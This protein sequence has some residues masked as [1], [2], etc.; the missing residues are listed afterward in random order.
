[1]A[2]SSQFCEPCS[3]ATTFSMAV[4]Y[5]S[6][7][8]ESLCSDCFSV[9][10][11]FKAFISHHVIDA[12]V[13]ADISFELNKFC[14]DHK[15]MVL[16]F[17]CSDHDDICCKSC[18][19]D[20]HRICGKIKPL[21]VA[22][23]GVKSAT[24]LEDFAS[25]VKYLIDTASKVR[26][27]KQKSKVTW[28]SSTDSVKRGVEIFRSRILKRIDDMEE[29]L[30]LEVNAAN[31]KIVAQTGEEM[32]AVEKYMSDIQDISH[33]FDFIRKN[34]SEKQIFRLIKTL[35]TGL[36]QKSEELEKLISSLTFPQLLFKES[37][38]L[39]KMETIGSVT[40]ET[41]PSD[42][43]YQPPKALQAQSKNRAIKLA[44]QNKFEF[45]STIPFTCKHDVVITGIGVT[46][47]DH[48]LLCNMMSTAVMVLSHDGKQ[49]NDIGL[50]GKPWGIVVVP[51][52]EEAIVT[53]PNTNFIQIINTSTMRA[54]QKIK[55]PVE[56]YG[57]T[58]IDNDIVLGNRGVIYIINREGQRLNTINV[59]KGMMYS[60][61]CGKD[62]TLY[63]CDADNA[64]LYG[65]QQDGT[66]LFSFSFGDF[67]SPIGVAAAA[68][69]KLYVTA[70]DSNNVHCFTPDG[71]H[72]GI[73]LKEE[74]G[75][76]KPYG[77]AFS[78]K[79]SKVFIVNRNTK[80]VLKFSHY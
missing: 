46:R 51:D 49:L 56:C 52:K 63:C 37:N 64:T 67:G 39:S 33:Q 75:L 73:M 76:H 31:S 62:K 11:T 6:D 58:L 47:D 66:I 22:A 69:G 53:L 17:Y 19:A 18:I 54:E 24:M 26:E 71:R 68:N 14:S 2:S 44:I 48:L 8:D 70:C 3:R 36:S 21:D 45:D 7:C 12:Q 38:L 4:K 74:H 23:K 28:D 16:D 34:G 20:E 32:K 80:S 35:E 40:I 72:K 42:M 57:I 65:I 60:L 50:G 59:G 27:Q 61:Y 41:S 79:S 43:N 78:T 25:E 29:K 1:M 9:H 55:V 15:D 77:I 5:C 13:S 10:G 30:M